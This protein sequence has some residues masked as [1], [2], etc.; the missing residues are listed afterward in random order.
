MPVIVSERVGCGDDLVKDGMN[1][2]LIPAHD[3]AA[4]V[5]A[6]QRLADDVLL[7][8][9]MGATGHKQISNWR[10]EDEAEIIT[11]AWREILAG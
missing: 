9:Q 8:E 3:V 7:R 1:G 6:M 4:L 10:L 11:T 2:L 5:S